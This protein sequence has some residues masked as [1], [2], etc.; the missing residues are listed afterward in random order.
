MTT[1]DEAWEEAGGKALLR[2]ST[3]LR[4]GPEL[5]AAWAGITDA[6]RASYRRRARA[7]IDAK[8]HSP[9]GPVRLRTPPAGYPQIDG[10]EMSVTIRMR[11]ACNEGEVLHCQHVLPAELVSEPA[12]VRDV[13]LRMTTHALDEFQEHARQP[14]TRE[15]A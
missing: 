8:P 2:A 14:R 4:E 7:V 15:G 6:A 3:T 10:G 9:P 12:I 13:V 1:V 11:C 5:D